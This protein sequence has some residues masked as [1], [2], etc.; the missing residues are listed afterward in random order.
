MFRNDAGH[1]FQDVSTAGGFGHLQKGHAVAFGDIDNDGNQ[2]VF[3]VMG[4]VYPNDKFWSVLYKNPG[5]GKHWLKLQLT[6]VKANHFAVGAR[7]RVDI[8]ENGKQRSI[9]RDVTSGG[10]FGASS[11]RPHIGTGDAT[12]V[13][14]MEIRWPGSGLV[15]Q[16]PG[17]IAADRVYAITEGKPDLKPVAITTTATAGGKTPKS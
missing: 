16:F 12:A 3:E 11:L 5:H 9:Y 7:I 17:P 8:T 1:A 4:G 13:D 6:G 14:R 10:S 15:Q 2:D